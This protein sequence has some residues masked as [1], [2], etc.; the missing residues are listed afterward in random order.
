RLIVWEAFPKRITPAEMV[1]LIFQLEEKYKP[2]VIG[3]EKDGL[4]EFL[5]QPLRHEQLRRSTLLPLRALKAPKGKDD[6]IGRLQPLFAAGDVTFAGDSSR[7]SEAVS[8]FLAFPTGLKDV[9]NAFAYL[10]GM[11]EGIPVYED[12]SGSNIVD[13]V[14]VRP[15]ALTLAINASAYG[16]TG[17]LFQYQNR[18]LSVYKDWVRE[19]DAGQ[20]VQGIVEEARLFANRP[21]SVI[22]PP[23][24]FDAKNSFGL[25]AALRGLSE[26]RKGGDV[27]K[28][29]EAIRDMLRTQVQ[30]CPRLLMGPEASW[31][32]RALMGGYAREPGKNEPKESLYSTL[33]TALEAAIAPVAQQ[34]LATQN[35]AFTPDGRKYTTAEVIYR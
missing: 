6:F 25:L 24:H 29:R 4:E 27:L 20:C 30:G 3:V 11:R 21:V 13:A 12:A 7:F 9:P 33:I 32:V 31:T 22:A 18:V 28:G 1:D 5:M 23:V 19:N 17:C 14:Y 34:Q 35:I 16:V 2:V 8:Q 15:G 26:C 10:F